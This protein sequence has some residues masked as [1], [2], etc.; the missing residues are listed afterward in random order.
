MGYVKYPKRKSIEGVEVRGEV[1]LGFLHAMDGIFRQQ[2]LRILTENGIADPKAGDWYP[3][4]YF[5]NIFDSFVSEGRKSGLRLI[6][7]SV[8]NNAKWPDDIKTL[9]R[10]MNSFN[11]A[12]HMNHRRDGK[13]LYDYRLNQIIEGGIGHN[14]VFPPRDGEKKAVYVCGSFYPCDFDFGMISAFVKKFKPI[15]C[16]YYATVRHDDSK[17]CRSRG[18]ETCTYVIEW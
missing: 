7:A 11:A 3:L 4:K 8:V 6:G 9:G 13:E 5:M 14:I 15:N 1:I 18:G 2:A 10:A 16:N 17:P 12:Y